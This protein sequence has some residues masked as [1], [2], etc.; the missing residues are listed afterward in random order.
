MDTAGATN[1]GFHIDGTF[2]SRIVAEHEGIYFFHTSLQILNTGT[3]IHKMTLWIRKNGT[4]LEYTSSRSSIHGRHAGVDGTQV[5][6][7][8]YTISLN[9]NDYVELLWQ[10]DASDVTLSNIPAGTTPTTPTTPSVS[11][12]VVQIM[13]TQ[14]GPQGP[15]GPS[16]GPD[17][18]LAGN[19]TADYVSASNGNVT[20]SSAVGRGFFGNGYNI[21]HIA[22]G[23]ITTGQ[24]ANARLPTNVNIGGTFNAN[25]YA[26]FA[27]NVGVTGNLGVHDVNSSGNVT[28]NNGGFLF[29]NGYYLGALNAANVTTGQLVNAR[30]PT[31]VNIGGTFNANGY[32]TF[33]GNVGVT[34]NLGVHDVNSSGNV[35]V[36]NGGF[37]FGNGYYLGALN[38][39]NVTTGQLVNARLPTNVNIGGTLNANGAT[40]LVDATLTG[41]LQMQN[42]KQL[43]L[44]STTQYLDSV[45]GNALRVYSYGPSNGGV[46]TF[47]SNATTVGSFGFDGL[48]VTGNAGV[49]K[50]VT[51]AAFSGPSLT[52]AA[53]TSLVLGAG[54]SE[55]ARIDAN[56]NVG[57]GNASAVHSLSVNGTT[58]VRNALTMQGGTVSAP[59]GIN[60]VATDPGV[61]IEKRYA[62]NDR[63]GIGQYTGGVTRVYAAGGYALATLK[64]CFATAENTFTDALTCVTTGNV[65]IGTSSPA[66]QLQLSTDSAA[67]PTT[68]TWTISS[69]RRVKLNI[70][71]ADLDICYDT[72]KTLP[73]RRFTYDANVFPSVPDRSVVGWVAQEVVNVLPKAVSITNQHGFP[74]FLG[75]DVDQIYK[76]M[77]GALR[78]VIDRNEALEARV[79]LLEVMRQP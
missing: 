30:L 79:A 74:D 62:A 51:A 52:A 76:T 71:D 72:V 22:A 67:K 56:G 53:A 69:D 16:V 54:G 38:A 6:S 23:N 12:E 9:A 10:S 1:N 28:V 25:G 18:V 33:A 35:T 68:S 44:Y 2:I 36:N 39:A 4:D 31:N 63:Y 14:L 20:A 17:L 70:E 46:I 19:V 15:Q 42:L 75:L 59:S 37:L 5:L 21:S 65:G 49:S 7:T 32:A 13:Y 11:V 77:Y 64:L 24:L 43:R 26:T 41:N 73:L 78:K 55:K 57:I 66:Y 29:G 61:M 50:T 45:N 34:G 58:Y 60:F 3:Q 8:A 40:T 47:A 48:T 27:G